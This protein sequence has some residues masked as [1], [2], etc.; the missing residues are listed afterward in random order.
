VRPSPVSAVAAGWPAWFRTGEGRARANANGVKMGR[1]LKLTP[2]QKRE[3]IKRRDRGDE[4]LT[5]I[6]R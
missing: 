2:H 4:T 3:A 5:E 6:G 1:K